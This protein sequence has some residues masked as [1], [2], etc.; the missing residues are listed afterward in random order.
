MTIHKLENIEKPTALNLAWKVFMQFEAPE[1]SQEG[2]DTFR[3]F[4]NDKIST[5]SLLMYAAFENDEMIGVIAMRYDKSHISLFFVKDKYHKQSV[6][7]KLFNTVLEKC[8][9]DHMTVHS[10]PYAVG[11]YHKLGFKDESP[12]Q[13]TDGIRFT[14]MI[15]KLNK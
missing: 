5:D 6:G 12:E 7:R 8:E 13:L 14:P 15:L 4:I 10:S 11:F 2:I 1:Y 3:N 9:S